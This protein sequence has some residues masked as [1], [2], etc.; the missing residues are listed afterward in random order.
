GEPAA[1]GLVARGQDQPLLTQDP[2]H[3]GLRHQASVVAHHRPDLAMPPRGMPK[4]VLEHQLTHRP[5]RRL[6][7]GPPSRPLP[8]GPCLPAPPG[9]CRDA[10]LL[11][12]PR[13]RRP[14]LDPDHLEVFEG[15]SR[16]SADFCHTR[17]SIAASPSAW[18]RSAASASSCCSRVVGPDLPA[19]KPCLPASR[20][21]RLPPTNRLLRN[22][23]P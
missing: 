2:Q 22:L 3:R 16:P 10:E 13:G 1:L 15:P 6:G 8:L 21:F 12:P 17:I 4:R 9:P 5:P 14:G 19:I 7:P 18:V 20:N 23:L 11:T